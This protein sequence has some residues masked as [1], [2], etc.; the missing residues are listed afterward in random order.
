LRQEES[1]CAGECGGSLP[2]GARAGT[3]FCSA[4]CR[5]KAYRRRSQW[6]EAAD[7]NRT[8]YRRPGCDFCQKQLPTVS[9]AS[10]SLRLSRS[11]AIYCSARC[12]QRAYRLRLHGRKLR[13]ELGILVARLRPPARRVPSWI[14]R[15]GSAGAGADV[16]GRR[17]SAG[18]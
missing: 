10:A 13:E 8:A 6:H 15:P 9:T 16:G 3:K 5:Q 17:P 18:G 7:R 1:R 12:R 2:A 14:L 11:D 4:A